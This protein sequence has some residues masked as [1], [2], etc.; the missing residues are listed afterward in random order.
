MK[1]GTTVTLREAET[2]SVVASAVRVACSP[3]SRLRG[4][5]GHTLESGEGLL[6]SPCNGVHT[7]FMRYP[8]DVVF[9]DGEGGVLLIREAMP[10]N[11]MVPWV[12]GAHRVLELPAGTAATTGIGRGCKLEVIEATA[13]PVQGRTS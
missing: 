11:R 13:A 3:W 1:D 10:A 4:L 9:L 7:F 12:R 8:I 5:L 2:G 6:I